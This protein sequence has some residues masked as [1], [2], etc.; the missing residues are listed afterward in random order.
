[1][2]E[3]SPERVVGAELARRLIAEQCFVPRTLRPL[4][5]GWDNTVWLVDER[6]AFRFPRREI[7]IA[8]FNRELAA[9]GDI[10]A[11]VPL[12]IPV[13]VWVGEPSEDFPWPFYGA[14]AIAG[15]ELSDAELTFEERCAL[16][17][18]LG[19][20]L[21][22]L[23]DAAVD[24]DLPS[25]PFKRANMSTRVPRTLTALEEI[26]GLWSLP[27][28][29]HEEL[30]DAR[31]LRVTLTD[32]PAVLH[33]D[34]HPRH[35]LIEDGALSG[36]ID[37]GDVCRGDPSIDLAVTWYAL[38]PDGRA[39]FFAE[40]GRVSEDQLVRARVLSLFMCAALVIHGVSEGLDTVV[41]EALAG[42]ER[43]T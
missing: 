28:T 32:R 25:D 18:P 13:P 39:D 36:I 8:G 7:A 4:G 6:W 11:Q 26:G 37:W 33:G 35:L 3:W 31:R 22:K 29:V 27:K 14:E 16:G 24:A 5:E 23:H 19:R 20:F 15:V 43:S 38:P 21:R 40:Y 30:L 9:L 10:A 1:V 17:R 2:H 42:L 12:R 41:R 34:L